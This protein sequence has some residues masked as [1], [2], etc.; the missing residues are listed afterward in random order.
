MKPHALL[1]IFILGTA[2]VACDK[3][4]DDDDNSNNNNSTDEV[5]LAN[6]NDGEAAIEAS[7]DTAF[8]WSDTCYYEYWTTLQSGGIVYD[9]WKITMPGPNPDDELVID[10]LQVDT[11]ATGSQDVI[12]ADGTYT[13]GGSMDE[14]DVSVSVDGDFYSFRTSSAGSFTLTKNGEVWN[15]EL[16]AEDLESGGIGEEDKFIS[17][18]AALKV[19]PE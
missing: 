17:I 12:P 3:D 2:L 10:I 16:S 9:E 1:F 4:D 8:A 13:L 5:S 7:G 18:N 11:T 19:V 6:L 14:N 15:I